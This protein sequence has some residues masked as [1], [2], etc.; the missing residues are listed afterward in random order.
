MNILKA[1]FWAPC[2]KHSA[3]KL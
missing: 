3:N 2:I 1:W